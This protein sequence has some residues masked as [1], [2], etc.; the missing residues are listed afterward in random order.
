MV[1]INLGVRNIITHKKEYLRIE[2]V[3]Q[4]TLQLYDISL[5]PLIERKESQE[6]I[7]LLPKL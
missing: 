4:N 3:K 6:T 1:Y 2:V 7:R 5:K